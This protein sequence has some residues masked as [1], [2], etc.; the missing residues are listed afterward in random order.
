[1]SKKVKSR[2]LKYGITFVC[3]LA[4]AGGFAYSRGVLTASPMDAYQILSDA[5][6]VPGLLLLFAGGMIALANEGALDGIGFILSRLFRSLIPGASYVRE[7]YSD[8]VARKRGKNL[9]GF[10][11]LL[12]SGVITMAV[13]VV[14]LLLFF[15][16]Y[17]S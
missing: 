4:I 6:T 5:F 14:F 12:I 13:S 2:I 16:L 8:Y 7:R 11:F 1:M 10:G 15:S 17:N 3:V 9:N